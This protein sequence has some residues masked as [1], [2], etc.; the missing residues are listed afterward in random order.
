MKDNQVETI[1]ADVIRIGQLSFSF[2]LLLVFTFRVHTTLSSSVDHTKR[3]E[4]SKVKEFF[5][6][7][8]MSWNEVK[9][10]SFL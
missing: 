7:P 1:F 10:A 3:I 6:F 5:N 9:F 8:K 4:K 2:S